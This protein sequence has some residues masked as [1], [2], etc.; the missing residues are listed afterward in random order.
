MM[1]NVCY[2]KLLSLVMA[3]I[4]NKCRNVVNNEYMYIIQD[5]DRLIGS[6]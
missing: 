5:G 3:A 6:A 4:E 1:T 2:F